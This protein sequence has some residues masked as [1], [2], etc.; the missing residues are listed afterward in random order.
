MQEVEQCREQLPREKVRA[1]TGREAG[2][3]HAGSDAPTGM[4]DCMDAGGR[5]PK[6]GTSG[7]AGAIADVH[8]GAHHYRGAAGRAMDGLSIE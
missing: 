8:R 6:V 1:D 7:D 5:A 4:Y 3:G 2:L